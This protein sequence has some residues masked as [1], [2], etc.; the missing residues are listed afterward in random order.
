MYDRRLIDYLPNVLKEIREYQIIQNNS[1]QPEI[2]LAWQ[3]TDR[4]LLDQFIDT[5]SE[6]GVK[7]WEK[8]L[9]II[10][11]GTLTLDE[12]KFTIYTRLNEELPFTKRVL[13]QRLS[14]LCGENN[15]S[16]DLRENEYYIKVLIALKAQNN[17]NDV[18]DLLNRIIPANMI[19]ECQLKFNNHNQLSKYTHKELSKYT[20]Y[21]L[22]NSEVLSGD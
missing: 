22:R 19:I 9:N 18:V 1:L 20:Q 17:F 5:M 14:N 6:N 7:R 4:L 10:P 16:I 13:E 12:R 3:C 15:Y 2:T 8:I 21:E 11:K